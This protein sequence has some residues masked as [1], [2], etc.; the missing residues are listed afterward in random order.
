M[1]KNKL[2]VGFV[3]QGFIGK[4]Y[5]DDFE[6]RGYE[7]VRYAL[8]E[9]YKANKEK[10]K[11]CEIVFV[12]VPTPTVPTGK[13]RNDGKRQV[14][15]DDSIVREA[16]KVAGKNSIVVIK[17]TIVPGTSEL[18]QKENREKII[19]HSPE[20]LS[21]KTA[22]HDAANP[23]RNIIG[24][25]KDTKEY[26]E[27]AEWV[28]GLLPKAPYKLI[29][30]VRTAE[31]IKYANNSFLFLKI[32]FAHI[33]KEIVD[34][35]G[36]DWEIVRAAVGA[37]P[38]VGPSHLDPRG[39]AGRSCFIKDFGALSEMYEN[40]FPQEKNAIMALRGFEYKNAELLRKSNRYIDLLEGVYGKRD[41]I[42]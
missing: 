15:F 30:N 12:A 11:E 9:P 8:E 40:L 35:N 33:F 4:N 5:A 2:L 6:K 29:C 31:H 18:I 13:K 19:L 3:G 25:T 27:A 1:P 41:N 20:F 7:V 39:G 23:E 17:S 22:A 24:I 36:A 42:K 10:I 34:K 26:K 14:H 38:R 37:D 21:E 32:V 28:M 16:V